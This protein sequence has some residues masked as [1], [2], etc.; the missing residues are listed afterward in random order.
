MSTFMRRSTED[1]PERRDVARTNG[2]ERRW[3]SSGQGLYWSSFRWRKTWKP[4]G[5]ERECPS[6][7]R[8]R[9]M[10]MWTISSTHSNS[11]EKFGGCRQ[12]WTANLVPLLTDYLRKVYTFM[13]EGS[14]ADFDL[15]NEAVL[16]YFNGAPIYRKR[17]QTV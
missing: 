5:P 8:S 4:G 10:M 12:Y 7:P 14:T 15:G 17:Y 2:H 13:P 9:M 11:I 16:E 6:M 1:M 3:R